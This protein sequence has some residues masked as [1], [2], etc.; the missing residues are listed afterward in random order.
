MRIINL[1]TNHIVNP[2]GFA[3][4]TPRLS[5]VVVDAK[6]KHQKA[7]KVEVALDAD[8][9]HVLFNSGKEKD[10]D[11]L[12]FVPQLKL[13]PYTRYF[14]RVTVWTE[15]DEKETSAPAWFETAKM[16]D[17]WQAEWI[18]PDWEDKEVHPY[19]RKEIALEKELASARIYACGVG[20][21]E[22]YVNGEKVGDEV[23][24]P[25]FHAYDQW[26]QYQT[27]DVTNLL[28]SGGNALGAML[29]S[30]WYMGR[31]SFTD[32]TKG[33]YGD[34]MA[35]I[36]ELHLT[37][38]DGSKSVICSNEGWKAA[39]GPIQ[40]SSIYDGEF[41]D[42]NK[43]IPG[44]CEVGLDDSDWTYCRTLDLGHERLEE[45]RSLPIKIMETLK[46]KELIITPAGESVID[47]GQ[48]FVG[49]IKFN[50]NA[51]EGH[52][53]MLQ[54]GEVLQE[55]N[56]FNGNLRSAKAE[57][58]IVSNGQ[59]VVAEPHFTFYGGRYIKVTN[60]PGEINLDDFTGCVIYSEIKQIGHVK[61]AHELVNRLFLN[62]L[63]GQKGN[64]VD[65][66]TDCPQRDERMG[67][68]GDAQVF[69][70]TA[71]FN[72]D[73]AAFYGKYLYDMYKEQQKTGGSV[74][75]VIP[76]V[77][78][79]RGG[80]SAWGDAATVIP[81][82]TYVHTGD[83]G[84]LEQQ[85]ESMKAWVEFIYRSDEETGG[86]RLWTREF[87][88]GDWLALDTDTPDRPTGRTANDLVSSAY[89]YYSTLLTAKAA[90][91]IGKEEDAEH[92]FKLAEEIKAAIQQEFI[93]HRGRIAVDTQT[94]FVLFLF[95]DLVPEEFVDRFIADFNAVMKKDNDHL[96]TGFVGTPWLCRT[97]S[98]IGNDDLAYKLLMHE[99]YPSWLYA[100]KMGATTIWERWNSIRPNGKIGNL[101]MNSLNHYAYGS[102][103]EWVYRNAAG[104][105]PIEE[106]PGFRRVVLAPRPHWRLGWIDVSVNTAIGN[107]RSAWK[108][109][110]DGKLGFHV[111]VPFDAKA[112][113]IL[114]DAELGGVTVNGKSLAKA[115]LKAKQEGADVTVKLAAGKYDFVYM[116]TTSYLHTFSTH[117][118]LP[119]LLAH[120]RAKAVLEA[121]IPEEL[122]K[123]FRRFGGGGMMGRA[124]LRDLEHSPFVDVPM[125]FLDEL[126]EAL[127]DVKA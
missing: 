22:L 79:G 91:V 49:W 97:L 6:G 61:T 78:M 1:K 52:E 7:A 28:Q 92:Y 67:W 10:I 34:Q 33:I 119:E 8:F 29:G 99:D 43:E 87:T 18:T 17:P 30:G 11:S 36:Y 38:T 104:I 85:Y 59:P 25:G 50:L 108:I 70:G 123:R 54:W 96:K 83:K 93:T 81:W 21:Y 57:Y 100:V 23:L 12:A 103:M 26:L 64:F 120:P 90:E 105:R 71:L 48:N 82:N 62:A 65:V 112:K 69:S 122:Q 107:Y 116:P 80:S 111:E 13:K 14:W 110:E 41:Y 2:L 117:T 46:P 126:D 89:Y 109:A 35:L 73:V 101:E 47:F 76:S 9:D 74:P 15:A 20:L 44:W 60:W 63:W 84:I 106:R 121:I 118:P 95:L 51:P 55:D 75:H 16:D 113:M 127:K 66:P 31:F 115:D 5:W 56:F 53:V 77:G 45:R 102:I 124:S 72:M 24:T 42:V 4:D 39:A 32:G 86:R 19:L 94:A 114:P 58:H 3:L 27:Y 68:T 88:F 40:D 98:K 125:D 37:F